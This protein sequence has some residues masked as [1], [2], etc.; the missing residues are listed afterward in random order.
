MAGRAGQGGR[1]LNGIGSLPVPS[2]NHRSRSSKVQV[3]GVYTALVT[4][5][6]EAGEVNY[7]VLGEIIERQVEYRNYNRPFS[8]IP[9]VSGAVSA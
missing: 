4:P 2:P 6:D 7:E 3:K 8:P 5:F 9:A 1:L